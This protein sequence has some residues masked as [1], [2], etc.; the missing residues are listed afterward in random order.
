MELWSFAM[1]RKAY[2]ES[3]ALGLPPHQHI[4][5]THFRREVLSTNP[6]KRNSCASCALHWLGM[7]HEWQ[8]LT[9]PT[10]RGHLFKRS[11][12]ICLCFKRHLSSYLLIRK[13]NICQGKVAVVV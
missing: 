3:Y 9:H 4:L 7:H 12:S 5:Y 6:V 2:D 1:E 10:F 8:A 11:R 13:V